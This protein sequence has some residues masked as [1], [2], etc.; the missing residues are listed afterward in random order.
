MTFRLLILLSMLLSADAWAACP[1]S[2]AGPTM[3]WAGVVCEWRSG[4]DDFFNSD[5]QRCLKKL[6]SKDKIPS[7]PAEVCSLN[8]KYKT[9]ICKSIATGDP[10]KSIRSCIQ[11]LETIP[12]EVSSG[13]GG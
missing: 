1:K 8:A 5:V 11:S 10:T 6:N 2:V 4:T 3:N 9:E 7:A 12:R 13:I